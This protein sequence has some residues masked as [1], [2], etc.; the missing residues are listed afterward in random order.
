MFIRNLNYCQKENNIEIRRIK[1]HRSDYKIYLMNIEQ[2]KSNNLSLNIQHNNKRYDFNNFGLDSEGNNLVFLKKI[3]SK[4]VNLGIY[5]YKEDKL[6]SLIQIEYIN[7]SNIKEYIFEDERF[8]LKKIFTNLSFLNLNRNTNNIFISKTIICIQSL[9]RKNFIFINNNSNHKQSLYKLEDILLKITRNHIDFSFKLSQIEEINHNIINLN[10]PKNIFMDNSSIE[11][12]INYNIIFKNEKDLML[13]FLIKNKKE[14]RDYIL[15]FHLIYDND[16]LLYIIEDTLEIDLGFFNNSN[17][18]S[19]HV[20]GINHY[21]CCSISYDNKTFKIVFVNLKIKF[22]KILFSDE[23]L[24]KIGKNNAKDLNLISDIFFSNNYCIINI[25]FTNLVLI[26]LESLNFCLFHYNNFSFFHLNLNDI[27]KGENNKCLF[28]YIH[29]KNEQISLIII[30]K[31]ENKKITFDIKNVYYKYLNY[32]EFYNILN[33]KQITKKNIDYIFSFDFKSI[34]FFLIYLNKFYNSNSIYLNIEHIDY[35]YA[36]IQNILQNNLTNRKIIKNILLINP[37][38]H[39]GIFSKFISFSF[40]ALKY[41]D[42]LYENFIFEKINKKSCSLNENNESISIYNISIYEILFFKQIILC[43]LYDLF[44]KNTDTKKLWIF[45]NSLFKTK[46]ERKEI[47]QVFKSILINQSN[48]YKLGL[49]DKKKKNIKELINQKKKIEVFKTFRSICVNKNNNLLFKL[50]SFLQ[51]IYKERSLFKIT[52]F[53]YFLIIKYYINERKNKINKIFDSFNILD[54]LID[55][56]DELSFNLI[57]D[58]YFLFNLTNKFEEEPIYINILCIIFNRT[59]RIFSNKEF[60]FND[61]NNFQINFIYLLHIINCSFLGKFPIKNKL[62]YSFKEENLLNNNVY[63][64]DKIYHYIVDFIYNSNFFQLID[65]QYFSVNYFILI[66]EKILIISSF[67][68]LK[69][70]LVFDYFTNIIKRTNEIID[71]IIS[72]ILTQ[73][74][75]QLKY[76]KKYSKELNYLNDIILSETNIVFYEE[77][78]SI[79]INELFKILRL[80]IYFI[81]FFLTK[82]SNNQ[83]NKLL[84]IMFDKNIKK[85]KLIPLSNLFKKS[86]IIYF[87]SNDIFELI[88]LINKRFMDDNDYIKM[89]I[90]LLHLS[91]FYKNKNPSNK[92]LFMKEIVDYCC[93]KIEKEKSI[94]IKLE[95]LLQIYGTFDFGDSKFQEKVEF[96]KKNIKN[97]KIL[98]SNSL[99][100]YLKKNDFTF[101]FFIDDFINLFSNNNT[102]EIYIQNYKVFENEIIKNASEKYDN[103]LRLFDLKLFFNLNN[104]NIYKSIERNTFINEKIKKKKIKDYVEKV[105]N[106]DQSLINLLKNRLSKK[107]IIDFSQYKIILEDKTINNNNTVYSHDKSLIIPN[108]NN[109]D[110]S[111][112]IFDENI[113]IDFKEDN[114]NLKNKKET[115]NSNDSFLKKEK[116]VSEIIPKNES[117]L[118]KSINESDLKSNKISANTQFSENNNKNTN[119]KPSETELKCKY[120]SLKLLLRFF[121][122]KFFEIK[123][124]TFRFLKGKFYINKVNIIET[125]NEITIHPTNHNIS[126]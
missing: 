87:I 23:F 69:E 7:E 48:Q 62:V 60:L 44:S 22:F 55:L 105:I 2:K 15:I 14:L 75:N 10:T 94:N 90:S 53:L 43:I 106:L 103:L 111:E 93:N 73:N 12:G 57:Y 116:D 11:Y 100:D 19:F 102:R 16:E 27:F 89:I 56:E 40:T 54:I 46:N 112:I 29:S 51:S 9:N 1:P 70:K 98:N 117:N 64:S 122:K 82:I 25:N 68:N 20:K 71:D 49:I 66:Y 79:K 83:G 67:Q 92:I 85:Q 118:E 125:L 28:C 42:F 47:Y 58:K 34:Y 95:N 115:I 84:K 36:K 123:D 114:L 96:I 39:S 45:I 72:K 61:N 32:S 63:I 126:K 88:S 21:L 99:F 80:L 81:S 4:F 31:K 91:Y 38:L 78:T 41:E 59:E 50:A 35:L 65:S 76:K 52:E 17:I 108:Q 8:F 124:L 18:I 109:K 110:E 33:S 101:D 74:T 119:K 97:T 77:N 121:K 37:L 5:N 107:D 3:K 24:V 26:N 30:T 113:K 13:I 120:I 86:L 104:D 6:L